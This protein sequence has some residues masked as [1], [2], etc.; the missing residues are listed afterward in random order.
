MSQV[1]A[2][3]SIADVVMQVEVTTVADPTSSPIEWAFSPAGSTVEPSSWTVGAWVGS[4]AGGK[5]Q[6]ISPL[7]PSATSTVTLAEGRWTVWVRWSV[8]SETPV[9]RAFQLLVR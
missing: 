4:Y 7:L 8:G 1:H 3:E 5:V 6:A 2:V 9:E